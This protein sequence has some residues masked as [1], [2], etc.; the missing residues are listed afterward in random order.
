MSSPSVTMADTLVSARLTAVGLPAMANV[1]AQQGNPPTT[2]PY[3]APASVVAQLSG[4][5]QLL[6]AT[7]L[8]ETGLESLLGSATNHASI[9]TA[10]V[11]TANATNAAALGAYTVSVSQIARTQTLDSTLVMADPAASLFAPGSFT[12]TRGSG[13]TAQTT[14]VN[15]AGA[16][17]NDLVS[18][19]NQSGAGVTA[20][21]VT[22]A[23]GASLQVSSSQTGAANAFT[24]SGTTGDPFNQWGSYLSQ[25]GLH[26][27]QAA[28]DAAFTINGVAGTSATNTGVALDVAGATTVNLL[29]VGSST[30][31]VNAAATIPAD[32][33]SVSA[34]ATKLVQNYNAFMGTAVQ[35]TASGGAL[36]GNVLA[37]QLKS[38]L[39]Q[40]TQAT[41]TIPASSLSTLSALGLTTSG[42]TGAMT[43]NTST[44]NAAFAGD[45]TGAAALMTSITSALHAVLSGYAGNTGSIV[46]EVTATE[47]GM[48]FINGQAASAYPT[49]SGT[50]KQHLL[51]WSLASLDAPPALPGIS[52]FA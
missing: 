14:T 18:A 51:Q 32:L 8:A 49:L 5:G 40:A 21:V 29:A 22:G 37:D 34:A 45:G 7:S 15:V 41:Y 12:L 4:Y 27:T 33:A 28:Q 1:A 26:Q 25:L 42:P 6:S 10:G 50:V 16:S 30:V 17:L 47:S 2:D 24:L 23:Y 11:V 52:I 20:S 3:A 46:T 9:S 48:A 36:N 31:T 44:L 39:Y 13:E 35:L 19:I 38:D 43:L